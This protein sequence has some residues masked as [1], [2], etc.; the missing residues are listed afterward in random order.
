MVVLIC[1]SLIINDVE[2]FF[3]CLL[4]F[5]ILKLNFS[6]INFTSEIV[7]WAIVLLESL[8]PLG[9]VSELLQPPSYVSQFSQWHIGHHVSS[10]HGMVSSYLHPRLSRF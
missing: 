1:I 9:F 3:M 4:V 7:W 5:L 2:H 6:G 10:D 8:T